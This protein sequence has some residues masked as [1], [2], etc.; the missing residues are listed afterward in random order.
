M[1]LQQYDGA[2]LKRKDASA[3]A[4]SALQVRPLVLLA[5]HSRWLPE[6]AG[7]ATPIGTSHCVEAPRPA[8][9]LSRRARTCHGAGR[10]AMTDAV[11][12]LRITSP[13][14][15]PSGSPAA[16]P[17]STPPGTA[18]EIRRPALRGGPKSRFR[19]HA[20]IFWVRL[21][22]LRKTIAFHIAAHASGAAAS[23]TGFIKMPDPKDDTKSSEW[24]P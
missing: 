22:V 12:G 6:G 14:S 17:T 21:L 1:A 10:G 3:H 15:E 24:R 9:S 2:C 7:R 19:K 5:R 18:R 23:D 20:T 8:A 16:Q 13:G 4:R 11:G